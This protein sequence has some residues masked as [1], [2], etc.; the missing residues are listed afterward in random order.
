MDGWIDETVCASIS[1]KHGAVQS[2]LK[3]LV[4]NMKKGNSENSIIE[5]VELRQNVS[6][7]TV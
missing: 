6:T 1:K 4:L 2:Y 3:L 7:I 5:A